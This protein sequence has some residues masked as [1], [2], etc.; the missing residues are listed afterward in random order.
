MPRISPTR[1]GALRLPSR[2]VLARL[3]ETQARIEDE[4]GAQINDTGTAVEELLDQSP[5]Y[6]TSN[7]TT[8]RTMDADD[9]AGAIST[10]PTQ[11]EV[12][13]IR[14]AVLTLADTLATLIED[15]KTKGIF[16]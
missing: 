16:G 5:A 9:A 11:A 8:T 3:A 4:V 6:S 2:E 12:E 13:N 15:L 14:D 7:V 10:T 1:Q